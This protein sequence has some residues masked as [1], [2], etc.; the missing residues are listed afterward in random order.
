MKNV[1]V[2]LANGFEEIEALTV[3]DVLMR[4]NVNCTIISINEIEVVG[5]HN[6]RVMA[7]SILKDDLDV[8]MVV[9]PGGMP[10]AKNLKEDTRVIKLLKRMNEEK[11]KIAAICAAPIVLEEA[12]IIEGKN[13]TS[14]PGF[15]SDLKDANY[16]EDLVVVSDN[17]ITSRGPATALEFS[18]KLLDELNVLKSDELKGEMLYNLIK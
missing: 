1:A 16:K 5:A 8:D 9:L 14:Y 11:K 10:G 3:V 2:L 7:D 13:V 6:I 4:A 15:E 18:Y 12:K 17:I